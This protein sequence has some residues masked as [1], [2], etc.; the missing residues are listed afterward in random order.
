[1]TRDN[2][3]RRHELI[4]EMQRLYKQR[5]YSDQELA[6]RLETDRTNIHR[7]RKVM[8]KQMGIPIEPDP[9]QRGRYFIPKEFTISHIPLN[10]IEAAELYIAGRRLQQ[11]TR[12]SQRSVASALEKLAHALGK[13]LAERMVRAAAV[14]L[15]QEQDPR[16]EAI[17]ATLVECWLD[18]IP[19]RITH[20]KLHGEARTYRV[21]PYQL[22]PSVWGDGIYLIGHSEW[23]GKLATFK[24]A[25]IEKAVKGTGTFTMPD[26][27]DI[28]ELLNH[29]WG[30][31]HADEEPETV[32][33]RF[34]RY[35][36]P[37][38]RETLWHP[39]QTLLVHD[40]GSSEWSARVAEP[41]EM[42]PWVRGWGADV[43][44]LEPDWVREELSKTATKLNRQYSGTV[45]MVRLSHYIPYA[46]T[47]RRN[48]DEVHAL[49]YHLIDVGQ[50][51]LALWQNVLTDGIRL[52]MAQT[53]GVS[54]ADCGHLMAFLASLHDLGKASA[55]YQKKYG[56]AWLL[57]ELESAGMGLQGIGDAFHEKTPHGTVSMWALKTLLPEM[58]GWDKRISRK[59]A[60]ALG[61]HHGAWPPPGADNMLDDGK[62]PQW[63][64]VR[65][66]LIGE[67]SSV[68]TPPKTFS[69]PPNDVDTNTFLTI[70]SGLT[71]VADWIG[72]RND[73]V[74]RYVQK[75]M[76]SRRYAE[77]AKTLAQKALTD[78]G[79]IGWQPTGRSLSFAD[80]F[81]YLGIEKPNS[82]QEKVIERAAAQG[83]GTLLI[84]EA[85]TGQGKTEI[86]LYIAERWLQQQAGRG[87]YVAMP[88][89]ATSNQMYSRVGAFL[90]RQYP[91]LPLNYHLV[92]GQAAWADDLKKEVELQTVGD[93]R[94]SRLNAESWFMPRKRTLLAPFG[95]GTVDQAFMSVLQT[96][97]FFVR[98]FGLS[99]K[100][101][102]FDEV[103]A[104]D[105]YMNTLFHRLLTWLNAIGTSVIILS[106]TLPQQ[107]RR[108]LVKA[109]TG[110]DLA[111]SKAT[112]PALTLANRQTQETLCLPKPDSYTVALDWSVDRDPASIANFLIAQLKDGGCAAVICNTVARTQEIYRMLDAARQSGGL[113]IE[114]ADLIL[115][116]SAFPPIWRKE[117]ETAVLA[118]FKK[119]GDR[120]LRAIVVATQVIE[121]S[122]DIDF[123]LMISD[124][125][126]VDLILQR[127]GR[128]HRHTANNDKRYGLPRRL[129]ITKPTTDESGRPDFGN[130]SAIYA[131]YI[132]LRSYLT[133]QNRQEIQIPE[134]TS[135]LIESVYDASQPLELPAYLSA[136]LLQKML[137]KMVNEDWEVQSK[138][139][140]GLIST[141]QDRQLTAQR[142]V[143]LEEENPNC[144]QNISGKDTR[145]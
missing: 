145:H 92:H 1:M 54:V 116:H 56:P 34:S 9:T 121:Q 25:R 142:I 85:P 140:L 90:Q 11:Q 119:A 13:P 123:D 28:H 30:I 47:N 105:T 88:T 31:W 81:A 2:E 20:R 138:A 124:L 17:F 10:R 110:Q 53:L 48:Q 122:L 108:E 29:A 7:I 5:P 115:F 137:D 15:D 109:Y 49:L 75:P 36:T 68:F 8:S 98:L 84:L 18:G 69:P 99:H 52:H 134:H 77:T 59:I 94:E 57:Q 21:H 4:H 144:S 14:V 61:G 125:A 87:L 65:R 114:Q 133:L 111:E 70:L 132:L 129:V 112:Y 3:N 32:K 95:V 64:A 44:V 86:A 39:Q 24:L 19:V 6:D 27:F 89:Q 135:A 26:D 91:D 16:Q 63:D 139:T 107:S 127:A 79:W 38:V 33:L 141:P 143:G 43:E 80:A 117:I 45:E 96:R 46:K 60:I 103:H 73:E 67:L 113:H 128:L 93:D 104:Y 102:I 37:R 97:H 51:A 23:H 62:Y 82:I 71:S 66:D 74:F 41:R 12:T 131:E 35:V 118:K 136:D 22:E 55:A 58:L 106:A 126:P 120:P 72:S 83:T 130:D 101:I 76:S 78:L 42:L 100:V 40:D 50:V